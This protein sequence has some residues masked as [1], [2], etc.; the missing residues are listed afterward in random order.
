[1]WASWH[2]QIYNPVGCDPQKLMAAVL[3]S[4]SEIKTI[5]WNCRVGV[6][7]SLACASMYTI[8]ELCIHYNFALDTHYD[9]PTCT[10]IRRGISI[11]C[12][13]ELSNIFVVPNVLRIILLLAIWISS[14]RDNCSY[15]FYKQLRIVFWYTVQLICASIILL[16]LTV[17]DTNKNQRVF[18]KTRRAFSTEHQRSLEVF[19][20]KL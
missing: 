5:L 13:L 16:L 8:A 10:L 18:W 3:T 2:A 11:Y 14:F 9:Y 17:I 12:W 6:L 20:L 15:I 1:M 7:Y 19:I 4:P